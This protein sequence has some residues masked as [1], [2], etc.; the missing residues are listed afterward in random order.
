MNMENTRLISHKVLEDFCTELFTKADVSEEDAR[1]YAETLVRANLRGI[2]SHGVLRVP[3]YFNRF[4]CK[5]LNP[6]PQFKIEKLAPAMTLIDADAAAGC[7]VSK[8]A[9]EA[10]IESA[11]KCGIGMCQVVNSNHF[12]AAAEYAQMAV[13]KGMIGYAACTVPTLITAPGAK[14]KLIGNNPFALGIPTYLEDHPFMLDMALS[15]VA[16]GKLRFAAAKGTKIPTSWAADANGNPTDDPEEALKGFL[17][18]VGGFKGLGLA[19]AIDIISGMM[20]S[21]YYADKIKSMYRN[22][23]EPSHIG[24]TFIAIN[25]KLFV[26][27]ETLKQ[28]MQNF[29]DYLE[30]APLVEGNTNKL[31]FP[32]EIEYRTMKKRL[33][34]GI[35]VPFT[36]IDMLNELKEKYGVKASLD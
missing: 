9:M 35:P 18:P 2:D 20:T 3:N 10:A 19:Y 24:Q 25:A 17:L 31:C 15:V 6:R 13:D 36:T 16:E 5:A 21:D 1:W 27:E 26:D 34:E 28:R 30:A 4:I 33:E 22:P 11:E 23:T 8:V 7:V 12:G 29:H 14:K 32:G